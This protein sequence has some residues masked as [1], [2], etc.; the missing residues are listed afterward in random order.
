MRMNCH[1]GKY[2][3][4]EHKYVCLKEGNEKFQGHHE[5]N[6]QNRHRGHAKSVYSPKRAEN[7]YKTDKRQY[8]YMPA[9]HIS[10]KTHAKGESL[11]YKAYQ[12]N[13]EKDGIQP[14]RHAIRNKVFKII[15]IR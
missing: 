11:G 6:Q 4:K 12:L 2:S 8:H 3:R 5:K 1:A 7:K 9:K 15:G 13:W 14:Y 10:E